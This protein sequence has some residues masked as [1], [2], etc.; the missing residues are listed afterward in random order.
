MDETPENLG[1]MGL[2]PEDLQT[3]RG[4][5][6]IGEKFKA[7]LDK[8]EEKLLPP[9]GDGWDH[10]TIDVDESRLF[11]NVR[12][13]RGG[14]IVENQRDYFR[15]DPTSEGFEK[16]S[17][18]VVS[19]LS[20]DKVIS[21]S[22]DRRLV[23]TPFFRDT[24]SEKLEFLA[25]DV[26]KKGEI[27]GVN[28]ELN[29]FSGEKVEEV[30]STADQQSTAFTTQETNFS[31]SYNNNQLT[32][33][34][35]HSPL[36]ESSKL[37]DPLAQS[38]EEVEELVSLA[39]TENGYELVNEANQ[40]WARISYKDGEQAFVIEFYDSKGHSA[41]LVELPRVIDTQMIID[42]T[43]AKILYDNPELPSEVDEYWKKADFSN[44]LGIKVEPIVG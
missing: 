3:E 21:F 34:E 13:L 1:E 19:K 38:L 41:Y 9:P 39:S 29:F 17:A 5:E 31:P 28:Y 33:L 20:F 44:L 24:E 35:I 30:G 40:V 18:C 8:I 22:K 32:G 15:Y 23:R 25:F 43:R 12:T 37:D 26:I 2:P 4:Q 10:E 36:D 14:Q 27:P 11:I 6:E 16:A 7:Q 42:E